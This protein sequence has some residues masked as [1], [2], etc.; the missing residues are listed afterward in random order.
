MKKLKLINKTEN[1]KIL[2]K[3]ISAS[4]SLSCLTHTY[5][6]SLSVFPLSLPLSFQEMSLSIS[7][8]NQYPCTITHINKDSSTSV[9]RAKHEES[10]FTFT[11]SITN[12][13]TEELDLNVNDKIIMFFKVC[14]YF[15]ILQ[16]LG[17]SSSIY[18][19]NILQLFL[20]FN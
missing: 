13:A 15:S 10:G 20:I 8:R 12:F 6:L 4:L 16:S 3:F 17:P 7:A 9:V 11:A 1:E 2:F 14:F 5:L 18:E 19:H